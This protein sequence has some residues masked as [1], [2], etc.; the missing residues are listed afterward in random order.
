MS[1]GQVCHLRKQ[2]EQ[3]GGLKQCLLVRKGVNDK[4]GCKRILL[5]HHELLKDDPEHLPTGFIARLAGCSCP[6]SK[7]RAP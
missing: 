2:R 5:Q 1:Y 6:L 7:G 4:K 3:A